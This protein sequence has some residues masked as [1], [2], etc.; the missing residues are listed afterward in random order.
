M[1]KN[2]FL[3]I[4]LLLS[5][6]FANAQ[7]VTYLS[8]INY[9][10][11][12]QDWGE[13][14]LDTSVDNNPLK[15]G[16]VEFEKG[17]GLHAKAETVYD[18]TGAGYKSF[19]GFVG[20]DDEVSSATINFEIWVDQNKVWESGNVTDQDDAKEFSVDVTG[21]TTL[22]LIVGDGGTGSISNAHADWADVKLTSSATDTEAPTIPGNLIGEVTTNSVELKWDASKDNVAVVAYDIYQGDSYSIKDITTTTAVVDGLKSNTTYRFSVVARDVAGNVSAKSNEIEVTTATL[23][24]NEINALDVEIYPNPVASTLNIALPSNTKANVQIISMIGVVVKDLTV[25]SNTKVDVSSLA[26][27]VYCVRV[28]ADNKVSVLKIL[29]SK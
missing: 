5:V 9:V 11:H 29:V 13:L 15:I 2:Y 10:S 20:V 3:A 27:G 26:E 12:S 21:A 17:L 22:K 8:D 18:L 19:T 25:S 6:T 23:S 28:A 16:G 24:N 14:K 7:T 1:K 4:V